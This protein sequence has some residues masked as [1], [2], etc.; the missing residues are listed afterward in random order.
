MEIDTR[1]LRDRTPLSLLCRAVACLILC[2]LA[3]SCRHFTSK[4]TPMNATTAD[5]A[6]CKLVA[7]APVIFPDPASNLVFAAHLKQLET[8]TSGEQLLVITVFPRQSSSSFM[9][10]WVKKDKGCWNATYKDE[11]VERKAE[12]CYDTLAANLE[13]LLLAA[14]GGTY[15]IECITP[16]LHDG[17]FFFFHVKKGTVISAISFPP[18][19]ANRV[20]EPDQASLRKIMEIANWMNKHRPG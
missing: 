18:S 2:T 6:S 11:K 14:P 16:P 19:A 15:S 17:Y 13:T 4:Q 5:S 9:H 7:N 20:S 12:H 8:D 10:H 3:M 1:I